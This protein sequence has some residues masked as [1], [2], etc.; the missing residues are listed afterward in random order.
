VDGELIALPGDVTSKESIKNLV[1]ELEGKEDHLDLLMYVS[2]CPPCQLADH[3]CCSLL[4]EICLLLAHSNNA[5]KRFHPFSR[6]AIP[7]EAAAE[8]VTFLPLA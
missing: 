2:L 1:K 8:S 3:I 4:T 7:E 5:G 6:E